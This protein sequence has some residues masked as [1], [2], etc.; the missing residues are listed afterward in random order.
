MLL[1]M[2]NTDTLLWA[3]M[4]QHNANPYPGELGHYHN[5]GRAR[6]Y[7]LLRE[8]G[9]EPVRYGISER[10]RVCMEVV[11]KRRTDG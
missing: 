6:L 4:T 3:L 5:F 10:Y 9:L 8:V 1:S 7:D 2:P 11:A